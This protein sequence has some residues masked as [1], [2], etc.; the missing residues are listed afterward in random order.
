MKRQ[1]FKLLKVSDLSAH[2]PG[3]RSIGNYPQKNVFVGT[4][5]ATRTEFGALLVVHRFQESIRRPAFAGM[6]AVQLAVSNSGE[7]VSSG[8]RLPQE[9]S[10]PKTGT[11]EV[12]S[13]SSR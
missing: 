6:I 1:Q 3:A 10:I 5:A 8:N 12:L 11:S 7:K 2:R 9:A 13:E 4:T